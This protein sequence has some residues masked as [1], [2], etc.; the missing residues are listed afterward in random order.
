MLTKNFWLGK[1]NPKNIALLFFFSLHS[2]KRCT[3]AYY[4]LKMAEVSVLTVR[5]YVGNYGRNSRI[6]TVH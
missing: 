2:H 4:L 3:P 5:L 1:K 6:L